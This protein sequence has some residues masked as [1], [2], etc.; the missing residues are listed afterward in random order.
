MQK[1]SK[2]QKLEIPGT[3]LL[4]AAMRWWVFFFVVVED[5]LVAGCRI[6]MEAFK[7]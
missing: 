7:Q 3:V 2:C 6:F 1:L 5:R 4:C